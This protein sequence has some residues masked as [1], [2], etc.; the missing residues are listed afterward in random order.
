MKRFQVFRKTKPPEPDAG[1][2][3][4]VADPW[5]HPH[6]LGDLFGVG[7]DKFADARD[8]VGKGDLGRK[9][10]FE[11]CFISSALLR[12]VMMTFALMRE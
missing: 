1:I 3:E 11:A 8:G 6:P 12:S 7:S 9:K 4:G 5:V 10:E 2:Q